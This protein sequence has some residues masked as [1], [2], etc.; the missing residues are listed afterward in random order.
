ML[1]LCGSFTFVQFAIVA[2][3]LADAATPVELARS[4]GGS[5]PRQLQ[6]TV[7]RTGNI[8]AVFGVD[9]EVMYCGSS[10][11]GASYGKPVKLPG[12]YVLSLGMRRGPRIAASDNSICITAIAGK[13]GKGQDGDVL[14]YHSLDNGKSWRGPIRV[15]G[16]AGSAREGLHAMAAGPRGQMCCVWLDL[17]ERKTEVYAAVSA[18]GGKTWGENVRVY[19]SPDGSVCECCH[20]SVAYN[21]ASK[22]HVMWRNSLGGTRDM[23]IATSSNGG[24]AFSKAAKL[25]AGTW[26][27]NACPMDGGY[28]A[29]SPK[30]EIFT[31]WRRDKEVF[32]TLPGKGETRL[33]AGRQ[34]WVAATSEGPYALWLEERGQ[35]MLR[36]PGSG[37]AVKLASDA[38][39][40]VIASSPAG[41]NLVVAAWEE[42]RGKDTVLMSQVVRERE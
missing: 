17:R 4:H 22:L 7:D 11:K 27:L 33:A 21:A 10:D 15:N 25:G 8:H 40:P 34:P 2:A 32:L 19:Q 42:T 36:T 5:Q 39:D 37:K 3:T 31:A 6:I 12:T 14:A 1:R 13:Q 29:V 16:V 20:P 23:Y 24:T 30:G 35:L 28:L 38:H 41:D 18:D 9:N 26:Q